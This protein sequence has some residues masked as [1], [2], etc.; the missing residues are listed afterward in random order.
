MKNQPQMSQQSSW[1]E[2][3]SPDRSNPV[4]WWSSWTHLSLKGREKKEKEIKAWKCI[5]KGKKKEN[6]LF[7]DHSGQVMG[8]SI[9]YTHTR[10]FFI[11]GWSLSG[12][13]SCSS[14]FLFC[15]K[16]LVNLRRQDPEDNVAGQHWGFQNHT[17]LAWLSK[18]HFPSICHFLHHL[19]LHS[20]SRSRALC[21]PR[22]Q[23]W[24]EMDGEIKP[25]CAQ[26]RDILIDQ[27]RT[28]S[29]PKR[30][31]RKAR[32]YDSKYTSLLKSL[33]HYSLPL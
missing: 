31:E 26:T 30:E 20:L 23:C 9:D 3:K 24:E 25:S 2:N 29:W 19:P 8:S 27:K 32:K 12:S 22:Q 14:V 18:L 6:V 7:W 15:Y 1:K 21:I 17:K 11:K 28:L 13:V 16:F 5:H 10:T 33:F 4:Y